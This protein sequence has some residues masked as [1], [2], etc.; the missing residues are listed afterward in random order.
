VPYPL[1]ARAAGRCDAAGQSH[2]E[3]HEVLRTV[4][5]ST[6]ALGDIDLTINLVELFAMVFAE[7]H[8]GKRAARM[9][10]AAHAMRQRAELPIPAA[11]AALI[12]R[13]IG[14]VRPAPLDDDWAR[15]IETGAS[16]SIDDAIEEA[17]D[18][19]RGRPPS[20]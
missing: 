5:A 7:L 3:A 15:N 9:I 10:G 13:S 18:G 11:D 16:Y 12:D 4:A 14:K 8:D 19:G 1:A 6:V 20:P 2:R 17:L